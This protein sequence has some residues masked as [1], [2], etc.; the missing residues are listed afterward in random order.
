MI[1][2]SQSALF[3]TE[4][5]RPLGRGPRSRLWI[6]LLLAYLLPTGAIGA[7]IGLL[8]YQASRNAM[9]D[10]LGEA[11]RASARIAAEQVGRRRAVE[12]EPGDEQTRTYR[13]L[14]DKL[15]ALRRTASLRRVFLFDQ[16]EGCL[17]DSESACSIGERIPELAANRV[18]LKDVFGGHDRASVLFTGRDGTLY[19]SGFAPVILDGQVVAAVG[20]DGSATFFDPLSQLGQTLALVGLIALSLVLLVTMLVS[21]GIT[22]PLDRLAQ[23]ARSIGMGE[24]GD[25]IRVETRD[26]IGTLAATLNDMRKAIGSRDR[27]MQLMLSGIA[28]EVRNPLGGMTL[29]VGLLR[30]EIEEETALGYVVRIEKEL[31]Y[32]SRVV[33]DFLDFARKKAPDFR[34]IDPRAELEQ[35]RGLCQA[36]ADERQVQI[37]LEV[38]AGVTRATWDQEGMRRAVLNLVNNAIQASSSGGE[39]SLSLAPGPDDQLVLSVTDR[40]KGIPEDKR[41][42]VFEPFFT[43][44]QK[45]TG[46]GLAL[47]RKTIEDHGGAISI[48]DTSGPGTRFVIR[49]PRKPGGDLQEEA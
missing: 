35:I 31:E 36:L 44:R 47:V 12:L 38:D 33:N 40:G 5:R 32:L 9:E 49:L 27:Q 45:G 20:V 15:S 37:S 42:Q 18:E 4:P 3:Q 16:Q 10:Q 17:A 21:R 25:E 28:H 26:E 7:G 46:L 43:T 22:R 1:R 8:A 34:S 2:P 23:A 24:L 13:T 48:E 19:K 41:E 30:E 11:L 6:K 39:V 29:F 14:V